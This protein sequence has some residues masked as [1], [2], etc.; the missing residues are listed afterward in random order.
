LVVLALLSWVLSLL[1]LPAS[2]DN[3]AYANMHWLSR[4][5]WAVLFALA[6]VTLAAS[7]VGVQRS[8]GAGLSMA[9]FGM[10]SLSILT[11]HGPITGALI[12]GLLSLSSF[13]LILDQRRA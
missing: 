12:Y 6:A 1:F 9:V 11:G 7:R 8:V 4:V 13:T 5:G 10:L 2:M 3:P